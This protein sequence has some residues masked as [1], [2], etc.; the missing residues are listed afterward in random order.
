MKK[1]TRVFFGKLTVGVCAIGIYA[2]A[3]VAAYFINMGQPYD[4]TSAISL[5]IC[6]AIVLH[7]FIQSGFDLH[8]ILNEPPEEQDEPTITA[9][10]FNEDFYDA[11][12]KE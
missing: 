10:G 1:R 8:E 9:Q 12:F 5:L 7:L 3:F 2:V 11:Y 6:S 4:L